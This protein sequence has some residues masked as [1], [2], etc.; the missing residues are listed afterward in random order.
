VTLLFKRIEV[1][2]AIITYSNYLVN[3]FILSYLF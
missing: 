2:K 3:P 1:T